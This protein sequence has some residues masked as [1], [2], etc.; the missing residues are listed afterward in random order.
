M[1]DLDDEV[2]HVVRQWVQKADN[3]L[4]TAAHTLKLGASGPTDT[5]CFHAQQCIEKYL[6]AMLVLRGIDFS[7]T[8]HIGTLVS[9]LPARVRPD[10]SPKEQAL[11]SDYA[12]TTRY[13]GDYER[14]PLAE[15][16]RAVQIARRVRRQ[17]R[18]WLPKAAL[19]S[20]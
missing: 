10:L 9:L 14:I 3:D 6:K 12:V 11:L 16:R 7:R 15:A 20:P 18:K 5:V 13:P 17:V 2:L 4:V 19:Q 1:F 8:H